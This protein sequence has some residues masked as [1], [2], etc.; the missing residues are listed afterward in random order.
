M[1]ILL[2]FVG[3]HD[4]YSGGTGDLN[5]QEGLS[6]PILSLLSA[7][8]FDHIYLFDTPRTKERS[9]HTLGVI[10]NLYPD[11]EVH[12]LSTDLFD[13]T[14]YQSIFLVL[15]DHI[16]SITSTHEHAN[17]FIA[18]A[19][20]TPQMHAC[21]VLLVASGTILAKILHIRP[22]HFVTA[23]NP[24]VSEID[25]LSREFPS[26]KFKPDRFGTGDD[27]ETRIN[28]VREQVGI[29]GDHPSMLLTLERGWLLSRGSDPILITG[30]T[31]TG[32]ELFASYIHRLSHCSKGPFVVLNC[33]A[34]PEDIAESILFGHKKGSFTS[35]ISDQ[36]GKFEAADGGTLFLDELAE[37]PMATQGKL[38]RVLQNGIVEPVGEN[39][40]RHVNVRIIAATNKD[41][42]KQVRSGLFREDLY[43]RL[44]SGKVELPALRDRRSDIP[45][46]AL[47]I[48][49][50][51]NSNR[52]QPRYFT[53]KGLKRL[54]NH[55]WGGNVRELEN[56]IQSTVNMSRK[57]VIDAE[58]IIINSP[59][60]ETDPLDS[61][62][63]PCEGF[64]MGDFLK[65]A[66]IQLIL[67][68]LESAN[69]NQ[70]K[71]ARMLG[72][73]PQ[74]IHKFLNPKE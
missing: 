37:L 53:T 12:I 60:S 36:K 40:G 27:D 38:L 67:K 44:S 68:A 65:E 48:L 9:E 25:L 46:L 15:K 35:A 3:F 22:P 56:T 31:G 41:L 70:S 61:L 8:H 26:V 57:G 39:R 17:Y 20:G 52:D 19:S 4:P 14:N 73:S 47:S 28:L 59:I 30:E 66:R 23:G 62:P 50:R 51:I 5:A 21:W 69:G 6:G 13:P 33:A 18:V 11:S 2:T 7:S 1:D 24:I 64:S 55:S 74:T 49:E 71:A 72:V 42:P 10:E 54:Y 16:R 34:I 45:I 63:E 32:K 58:D 43:Y 29:I